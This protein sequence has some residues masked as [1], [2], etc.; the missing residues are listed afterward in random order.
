MDDESQN[1]WEGDYSDMLEDE[2]DAYYADDEPAPLR[3]RIRYWWWGIL[4]KVRYWSNTCVDCKRPIWWGN[5]D[6]C[7][8]F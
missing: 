7:I 5:H 6:K 8:P 2:A 1:F 4:A 3:I